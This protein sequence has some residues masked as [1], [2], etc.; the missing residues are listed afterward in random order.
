MYLTFSGD[1]MYE[2]DSDG[3]IKTFNGTKLIYKYCET[4]DGNRYYY[5]WTEPVYGFGMTVGGFNKSSG[6]IVSSDYSVINSIANYA[7]VKH[8]D[9]YYRTTESAVNKDKGSQVPNLIR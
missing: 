5:S 9:V 3:N 7:F 1:I 2:S 4:V 6:Y 8:T